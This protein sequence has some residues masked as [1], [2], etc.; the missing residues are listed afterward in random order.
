MEI[1]KLSIDGKATTVKV[2]DR[3]LSAKI[4]KKLVSNVLY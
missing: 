2:T 1:Q 4:N 3:I